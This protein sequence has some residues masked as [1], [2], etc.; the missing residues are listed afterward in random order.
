MPV[1]TLSTVNDVL[2]RIGKPVVAALDTGGGS[3]SSYAE[4]AIDDA[5]KTVQQEGWT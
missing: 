5:S 3:L 4:R 2:R 1:S